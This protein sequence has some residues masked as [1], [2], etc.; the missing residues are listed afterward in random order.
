M[1]NQEV[2]EM[3]SVAHQQLLT[4]RGVREIE[5]IRANGVF[6]FLGDMRDSGVQVAKDMIESVGG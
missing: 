3:C 6:F 1:G 4:G 2:P 5:N